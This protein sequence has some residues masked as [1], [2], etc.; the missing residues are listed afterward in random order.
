MFNEYISTWNTKQP[1]DNG[2]FLYHANIIKDFIID[3]DYKTNNKTD[4][5]YGLYL[6]DNEKSAKEWAYSRYCNSLSEQCYVHKFK[7]EYNI[8]DNVLDFRNMNFIN[9][10]AS[11]IYNRLDNKIIEDIE[12]DEIYFILK[13]GKID[14]KNYDIIIGDR[15]DDN[16]TTI[17]TAFTNKKITLEQAEDIYLKYNLG[18]QYLI[19]GKAL[20]N[21][22]PIE[23]EIVDKSYK[24]IFDKTSKIIQ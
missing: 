19:R 7:L 1:K 2:I 11:V 13:D 5:G 17:F 10:F 21:L 3:K 6:T 22:Y 8:T 24:F 20:D 12:D 18:T 23:T 14:T 4:F 9:L 16:L 15:I